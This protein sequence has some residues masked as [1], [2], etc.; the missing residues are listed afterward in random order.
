MYL[1]K[2]LYLKSLTIQILFNNTNIVKEDT[3]Y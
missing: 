3:K 1:L 2:F